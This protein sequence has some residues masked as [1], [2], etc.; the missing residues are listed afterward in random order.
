MSRETFEGARPPRR[1]KPKGLQFPPLDGG[2]IL[3]GVKVIAVDFDGTCVRHEFPE[4][5][6]DV[7]GAV[8]TLRALVARGDRLI[9]WTVRD[10]AHLADA[11]QWFRDRDIELWGVNENPDQK[12]WSQ[13]RKVYAELYIDDAAFGAPLTPMPKAGGY[14]L[15]GRP[16]ID[17]RAVWGAL[18]F[19]WP[20][21]GIPDGWNPMRCLCPRHFEDHPRTA[22]CGGT[23]LRA[24]NHAIPQADGAGEA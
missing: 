3:F 1:H 16:A 4:V 11:V 22:E 6:P 9:L 17:W 15:T 2:R 14:A 13:S 23:P 19:E 5:G 21:G 7:P 24:P 12:A 8:A 10:G 20:F 18:G